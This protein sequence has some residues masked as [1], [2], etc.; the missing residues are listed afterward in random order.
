[1]REG[2][3]AVSFL[4]VALI[5]CG[6]ICYTGQSF[7]NKL[8][9]ISYTGPAVAATPVFATIYGFFTGLV[10]LAYNGFQFQA[11][12]MTLWLGLA[13]GVVLFLF[14]LCAINAAR[15]GPYAFQSLMCLSGDILVP[16]FF[17]VLWWRDKLPALKIVGIAVMLLSFVL[18]NRNGF[19]FEGAKKGY[20]LWVMALFAVN[21]VYGV[22]ID[23]QQRLLLQT[24]RNEMIITTFVV[25]A[26]VSLIYL[27][28]VQGKLFVGAFSMP[29]KTW[30][31][32]FGSSIFAAAAV[33]LLMISLANVQTSILYSVEN[34]GVL[35]M[36]T[37]LSA[38]V[39]KEKLN[40][41]MIIGIAVAVVSLVLLSI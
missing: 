3:F 25:S 4:A 39:L 35:I 38:V 13:N 20:F 21:G 29:K 5:V 27:L 11:S 40:R 6:V 8:Y 17:S 33:N 19:Q 34:G 23:S 7:F 30:A 28:A 41:N 37:L 16:L 1:M 32:A 18:F 24:E 31:F 14:N 15:S 2:T 9:S 12:S 22:L 36:S 10:T 26:I